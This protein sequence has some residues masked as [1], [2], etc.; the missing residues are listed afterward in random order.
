MELTVGLNYLGNIILKTVV[1]AKFTKGVHKFKIELKHFPKGIYLLK[2]IKGDIKT[3]TV[4][5]IKI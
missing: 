4:K 5:I 1:S 2:Y 3:G